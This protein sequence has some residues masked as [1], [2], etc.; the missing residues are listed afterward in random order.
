MKKISASPDYK[1]NKDNASTAEALIVATLS[2]LDAVALG[3]SLGTLFGLVI[4]LATNLLVF[5][6]GEVVGPNLGL[7]SQYFIGYEVTHWG[8]L[9]GFAYGLMSGF[10]LGFL[11][12]SLRNLI[13]KVY[14]HVLRLKGAFLAVNDHIDNP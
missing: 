9:I 11:I 12:A 10:V 3:V 5:K 7:L 6:G 1:G 2:K 14:I 13:I 8:S 4:F